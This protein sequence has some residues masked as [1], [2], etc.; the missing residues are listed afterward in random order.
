MREFDRYIDAGFVMS[1]FCTY[2]RLCA[3]THT[4]A[5][6]HTHARSPPPPSSGA[7]HTSKSG[8]AGLTPEINMS[9]C[10]ARPC[11]AAAR[12]AIFMRRVFAATAGVCQ[13]SSGAA[14]AGIQTVRGVGGSKL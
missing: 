7:G 14:F 12:P 1:L 11:K 4:T 8:R 5:H 2:Q 10:H 3:I 13:R 6:T 9:P